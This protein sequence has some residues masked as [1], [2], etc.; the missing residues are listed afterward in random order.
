MIEIR[1]LS[2]ADAPYLS[3]IAESVRYREGAADPR[4][5]YLVYVG[6]P[7]E[8]AA[9]IAANPHSFLA[10]LDGH[11]AGYILTAA[12]PQGSATQ[13]SGDA[14]QARIF[15]NGALL[16]DQ[17]GIRP[18]ARGHGIAAQLYQRL[19]AEA[20]PTRLTASIM[21]GPLLNQRSV[22]FFS[23]KQGWKCIGEFSEGYGFLWGIYEWKAD[24]TQGEAA[25][26]LGRFLDSPVL[27]EADLLARIE[28]IRQ[29]PD[30]TRAVVEKL[31]ED[32]LDQPIRP[33][34]WTARQVLH[35]MADTSSNLTSRIRLALT[36][37]QPP[38]KTFEENLWVEL[39]DA[40]TAPAE[41]SLRILDGLQARIARLLAS[42]P[43]ED[44]QREMFH[45]EQGLV[46]LDRVSRYLDW[47]GRHHTAQIRS[48]SH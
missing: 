13:A 19:L 27:T 33:G 10:L 47:H 1:P 36:E 5:G 37:E 15:G 30:Q 22:S 24:G 14:V 35:H 8:Y 7:D 9:R 23:G 42:R 32:Q 16:V 38:I 28:R 48:M 25:Y 21:H 3:A 17:I 12:D 18:H 26:P 40:K 31:S 2:V 11:P 6:K 29:L 44:F 43:L 34:A 20:K 45:P 41:E 46:K 39:A 4:S